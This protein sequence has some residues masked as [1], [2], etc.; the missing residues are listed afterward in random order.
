MAVTPIKRTHSVQVVTEE[1]AYILFY[2]SENAA[3]QTF[4]RIRSFVLAN[5]G[6]VDLSDEEDTSLIVMRDTFRSAVMLPMPKE[7]PLDFI[8]RMNLTDKKAN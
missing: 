3:F 4:Q 7:G 2:A 8:A 1:G 6:S 5:D